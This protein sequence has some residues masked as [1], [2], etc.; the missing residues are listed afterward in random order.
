[1]SGCYNPEWEVHADR[2]SLGAIPYGEAQ[3]V[4]ECLDYCGSQTGCVAVDVDLTK[5]PP[6]CWPHFNT[7]HPHNLYSQPGTNQYRLK[8]RCVV[9]G[10]CFFGVIV[11]YPQ[12]W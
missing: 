1:V 7:L 9:A 3:S 11:S 4:Q 12:S 2:N 6:A 8:N 5:Q 10:L